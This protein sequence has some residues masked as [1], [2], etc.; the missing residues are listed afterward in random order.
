M[1]D[2]GRAIA[3][4]YGGLAL[5]LDGLQSPINIG[6]ILRVAETF[7]F[8]VAIRDRYGVLG[9]P[10]KVNVIE[11]FACG[12]VARR[13]FRRIA[14]AEGLAEMRRGRRLIATSI[15]QNATSTTRH[16]FLPG[17]IIVLGNE[18]DGLP[19]EDMAAADVVLT[20]PMPQVWTPKP[21]ARNPIDPARTAPVA[22]DGRPN[23]NVAMA[24]AII[25]YAAYTSWTAQHAAPSGGAN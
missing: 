9:H 5:L 18:Y 4:P 24:G 10:E 1:L 21:A 14:D 11:D 13:G 7:Q 2:T 15:D 22:R 23:L 16:V 8:H 19:D 12:A 17:D 6:M 25:C 20:I 3:E